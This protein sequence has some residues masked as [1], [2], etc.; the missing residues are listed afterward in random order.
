MTTCIYRHT[1][2]SR[3]VEDSTTGNLR[4]LSSIEATDQKIYWDLYAAVKV[5]KETDRYYIVGYIR[6]LKE[7]TIATI[8]FVP[9]PYL[10]HLLPQIYS[11][12]SGMKLIVAGNV[13]QMTYPWIAKPEPVKM[14]DEE[15]SI[16]DLLVSYLRNGHTQTLW[17]LITQL[18]RM[19]KEQLAQLVTK[20]LERKGGWYVDELMR[21]LAYLNASLEKLVFDG[22][23]NKPGIIRQNEIEMLQYLALQDPDFGKYL[24]P[25]FFDEPDKEVKHFPLLNFLHFFARELV[26][27]SS[28]PLRQFLQQ[29]YI[30]PLTLDF[31]KELHGQ[32]YRLY[33]VFELCKGVLQNRNRKEAA[34]ALYILLALYID[35]K[36]QT[37]TSDS[38]KKRLA[39]LRA[40][41]H[42]ID[43]P[44]SELGQEADIS[45]DIKNYME[46]YPSCSLPNPLIVSLLENISKPF[47]IRLIYKL[48]P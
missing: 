12:F 9:T 11:I 24:S 6:R 25:A 8:C 7:K 10:Q 35:L 42:L 33:F 32:P 21:Q 22:L 2:G 36:F 26:F 40:D 31:V 18:H 29:K 28:F 45:E 13:I 44:F 17:H 37:T 15:Y 19:K 47:N 4:K 14:E 48:T 43:I 39:T 1:E 20:A 27:R 3:Y 41:K 34:F 38:E 46:L 30:G 23:N 5:R 16:P